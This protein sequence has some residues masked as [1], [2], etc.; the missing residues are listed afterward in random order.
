M[1]AHKHTYCGLNRG[2]PE[3]Y[4]GNLCSISRYDGARSVV[5]N[6]NVY[7]KVSNKNNLSELYKYLISTT[8]FVVYALPYATLKQ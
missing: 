5:W 6:L 3:L 4:V 7:T 2:L 1:L 8:A